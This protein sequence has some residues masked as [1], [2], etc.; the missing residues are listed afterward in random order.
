MPVDRIFT[1]SPEKKV[2]GTGVAGGSGGSSGSVV[3]WRSPF[4]RS[5][6][7]HRGTKLCI[8]STNRFQASLG[9]LHRKLPHFVPSFSFVF[10]QLFHSENPAS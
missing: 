8:H 5:I 4:N 3:R 6:K 2:G 7:D 10:P 9:A 1:E